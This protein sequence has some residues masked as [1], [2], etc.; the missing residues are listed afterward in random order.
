MSDQPSV[1]D[2]LRVVREFLRLARKAVVDARHIEAMI[3]IDTL[4]QIAQVE[5]DRQIAVLERAAGSSKI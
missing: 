3:E 4:M 1:V 5:T 2:T